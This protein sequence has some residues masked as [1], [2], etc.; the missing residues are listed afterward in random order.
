MQG[1]LY[2]LWQALLWGRGYRIVAVVLWLVIL[3]LLSI[4][5][6]RAEWAAE[7]AYEQRTDYR[8]R[9]AEGDFEGAHAILSEFYADYTD[10][11]GRWRT[12][13]CHASQARNLQERYRSASAYIFGQEA[14]AIYFDTEHNDNELIRLLVTIPTEGA[15]LAE[16]L[17]ANGMF[18]NND[19]AANPSA[20]DHVIYQS[21]VRFYNDRC[22][23]LLD[24]AL[25]NSDSLLARKI[26]RLYK[27]EV[28]T[29]FTP[30]SARGYGYAIADVTYDDSRRAVA[31][32]R[33]AEMNLSTILNPDHHV[34][35]LLQDSILQE[36][37][38]RQATNLNSQEE[39]NLRQEDLDG[40]KTTAASVRQAA[41]TTK[42]TELTVTGNKKI[43][44]LRKEFNR[45]F[46]YL[47]LGIYY[48]YARQQVA[49]G[50]S[51][52]PIDGSKTL[53]SVRRADSGG[54]ISISGNKKIKS[55][56]K[57]FDTVFGLYCQVC[58]TDST[59]SRYYTSGSSD[60]MTLS[61]FNEQCEKL[62]C[63]KGAWK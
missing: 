18:Y 19:A 36:S 55:L 54:S 22:D 43:E 34:D 38:I 16:G 62:G 57:E 49:K 41:P 12:N 33:V 20:I 13:A 26:M 31:A 24:M 21:W 37:R 60:E 46:P 50:E 27:T 8:R 10:E 58:Y 59:G 7:A 30:D 47:R 61:A 2:C 3:S 23:Q 63:K 6:E 15:P 45:K 4:P 44:T 28:V 51:I 29:R 40:K 17:H 25:T 32:R 9:C 11:L 53:A 39:H 52:T 5:I 56:E 48:S 35:S 1:L 42:S 14:A